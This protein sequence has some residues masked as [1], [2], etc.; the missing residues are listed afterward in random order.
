MLLDNREIFSRTNR[1]YAPPKAHTHTT[2]RAHL[3]SSFYHYFFI[4]TNHP[5]TNIDP[6]IPHPTL[7]RDICTRSSWRVACTVKYSTLILQLG[8]RSLPPFF[9]EGSSAAPLPPSNLSQL[10][11]FSCPSG[12]CSPIRGRPLG[13]SSLQVNFHGPTLVVV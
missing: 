2:H 12:S 10:F 7:S 9:C 13:C 11:S 3:H 4:L 5:S 6:L 8:W 1:T